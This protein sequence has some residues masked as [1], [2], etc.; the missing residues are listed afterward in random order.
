[1]RKGVGYQTFLKMLVHDGLRREA[2]LV[3]LRASSEPRL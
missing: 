1:M 3:E 2:R